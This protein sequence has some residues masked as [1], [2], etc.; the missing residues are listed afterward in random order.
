MLPMSFWNRFLVLLKL[1]AKYNFFA[2]D[3]IFV[4]LLE[5]LRK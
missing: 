2:E 5:N 4:S 3:I 1:P